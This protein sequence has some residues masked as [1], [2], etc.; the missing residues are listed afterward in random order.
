MAPGVPADEHSLF[1]MVV[2]TPLKFFFIANS[3]VQLRHPLGSAMPL[4]SF[5]NKHIHSN[6]N[7]IAIKMKEHY[8]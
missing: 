3:H 6:K 8:V 5:P 2:Q 4:A 1:V 7:K